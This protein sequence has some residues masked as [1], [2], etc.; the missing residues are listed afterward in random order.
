[1]FKILVTRSA[2]PHSVHKGMNTHYSIPPLQKLTSHAVQRFDSMSLFKLSHNLVSAMFYTFSSLFIS[3]TF[4]FPVHCHFSEYKSMRNWLIQLPV[5]WCQ[6]GLSCKH[7]PP[8]PTLPSLSCLKTDLNTC[9]QVLNCLHNTSQSVSY[10]TW[11]EQ[12]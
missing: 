3:K 12:T 5:P 9:S 6:S 8:L 1:M 4:I 11:D 10:F 7:H 2:I